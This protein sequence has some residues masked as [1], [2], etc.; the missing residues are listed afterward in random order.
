MSKT[1][2]ATIAGAVADFLQTFGRCGMASERVG[3]GREPR[4]GSCKNSHLAQR[5]VA[6]PS[7]RPRDRAGQRAAAPGLAPYA[8]NA[9]SAAAR[10]AGRRP[11]HKGTTTATTAGKH[12]HQLRPRTPGE[13]PLPKQPR[14]L[15]GGLA[16][17]AGRIGAASRKPS[18]RG[19]ELQPGVRRQNRRPDHAWERA[20]SSMIASTSASTWS[21]SKKPSR[22]PSACASSSD[23]MK[24]ARA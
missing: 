7:G 9:G 21:S 11:G 16:Q 20:S 15:A 17:L 13:R 14:R 6:T 8:R 12:A 10:A 4:E 5:R 18:R 3:E 23:L 2:V 24:A 19:L 22:S 1:A